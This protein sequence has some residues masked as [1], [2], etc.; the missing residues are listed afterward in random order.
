MATMMQ[1]IDAI[2]ELNRKPWACELDTL[3]IDKH[4]NRLY[5]YSQNSMK[6]TIFQLD[7]IAKILLGFGLSFYLSS[8]KYDHPAVIVRVNQK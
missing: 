7:E 6:G 4:E 8:T 5:I 3:T 1:V 2:S